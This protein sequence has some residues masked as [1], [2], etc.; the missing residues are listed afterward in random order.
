MRYKETTTL[1]MVLLFSTLVGCASK[2]QLDAKVVKLGLQEVSIQIPTVV[3]AGVVLQTKDG[4]GF[5]LEPTFVNV[6]GLVCWVPGLKDSMP[7]CPKD[8]NES[9]PVPLE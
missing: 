3:G 1:L 9:D 5:N 6:M 7:G 8:G 2:G 4:I